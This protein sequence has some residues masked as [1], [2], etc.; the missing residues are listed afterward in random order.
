MNKVLTVHECAYTSLCRKRG[1]GRS[2]R[3]WEAE[4]MRVRMSVMR[5]SIAACRGQ[6]STRE[7]GLITSSS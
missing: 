2:A 7:D 4:F 5:R 3:V 1:K 6:S